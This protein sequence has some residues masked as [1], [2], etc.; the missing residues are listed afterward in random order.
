MLFAERSV[1][2]LQEEPMLSTAHAPAEAE[3]ASH[4]AGDLLPA[5][6]RLGHSR[7]RPGQEEIIR[8]VLSGQDA[9]AVMP[10]GGGK[11]LCFQL[12]ALLLPGVTLVVSPLIALMRDQVAALQA[13]GI[14]A[15]YINSTLTPAERQERQQEL[16]R[17]HLVYVAPER[18]RSPQFCAAIAQVPIALLAVDE[19]HCISEWGHDFRPDYRR[20]GEVVQRLRPP[21]LLALTATATEEVRQDIAAQLHLREPQVVVHGFDRPSLHL[22]VE[23][24]G[25][26]QDKLGRALRLLRSTTSGV[27]IVYAATRKKA[28]AVAHGLRASGLRAR[29]Y[30]A[31]LTD[32]ERHDTERAFLS[33]ELPI[34]VATNAFGMGIDKRDVRLVLHHDLPRSPEAYYQEAGRAGRDG[35]PARVEMLWR[36][37]DWRTQE[38][39]IAREGEEGQAR[40]PEVVAAARQRLHF[41]HHAISSRSCLWRAILDYFGDPDAAEVARG[42]CGAC[43]RCEE[44]RGAVSVELEGREARIARAILRAASHRRRY[45]RKKLALLLGGSAAQGVPS[46]HPAFGA[47]KDLPQAEIGAWIQTLLDE[48]WL[49]LEG[50]EYPVVAPTAKAR[51][52]AELGA[53]ITRTRALDAPAT[54]SAARRPGTRESV[55]SSGDAELVARLR[56]W[57]AA[58]ARA[59]GKPAYVVFG[60]KTLHALAAARP[61]TAEDLLAVPGIGP[62]KAASFGAELLALV[63]ADRPAPG[64]TGS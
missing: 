45:G 7:F 6:Q 3:E 63:Q 33:G 2:V 41:F 48:G 59:L 42:G 43:A 39:L 9:I 25:G 58:R 15:T 32:E 5:L 17:Y 21:R 49:G 51:E 14:A 8:A 18:F 34:I 19:A 37:Q 38:F 61:G 57:R 44:R 26:D 35:A 62:A 28:E 23:R 46:W 13:R 30:H 12:P 20:L 52:A 60:D 11:S 4:D 56:A 29:P 54:P 53:P 50:D 55:P 31:G 36:G 40:D 64:V 22:S 1:D 27:A 47:L 10:T 24:A 16:H